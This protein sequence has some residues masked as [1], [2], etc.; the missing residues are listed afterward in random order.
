[1]L[2]ETVCRGHWRNHGGDARQGAARCPCQKEPEACRRVQ[3]GL[4]ESCAGELCQCTARL[5]TR[6]QSAS[7]LTMSVH[8]FTHTRHCVAAISK[9]TVP[10]S[11]CLQLLA[12]DHLHLQLELAAQR[13][14]GIDAEVISAHCQMP[15][16]SAVTPGVDQPAACITIHKLA[17]LV[18]SQRGWSAAA[19]SIPSLCCSTVAVLLLQYN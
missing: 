15:G 10:N 12:E 3:R 4:L 6:L 14:W 1:M 2:R 18:Y 11:G 13:L 19:V 7:V 17:V 9:P 8:S 16:L 5:R